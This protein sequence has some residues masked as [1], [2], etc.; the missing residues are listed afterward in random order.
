MTALI[1]ELD[2]TV[3]TLGNN[4][5]RDWLGAGVTETLNALDAAGLDYVGAGHDPT[6]AAAPL[7]LDVDGLLV[8]M[9]SVT[10]VNGDFVNDNLPRSSDPVPSPIPLG[11]EWQYELRTFGFVGATVNIPSQPMTVGDAW[12]E[13]ENAEGSGA[14][15]SE[16]D[17]LWGSMFAVFPELQD[18]VARRGHD[19]ANPLRPHGDDERHF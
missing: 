4:H 3:V 7:L 2:A 12:D 14:S 13:F 5:I 6:D 1:D 9:I 17:T 10:S 19:G 18:W 11:E 16:I 15:Q 8:G